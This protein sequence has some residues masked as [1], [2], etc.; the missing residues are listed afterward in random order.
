MIRNSRGRE[1]ILE[2][3]VSLLACPIHGMAESGPQRSLRVDTKVDARYY[4]Y[5]FLLSA[6]VNAKIDISSHSIDCGFVRCLFLKLPDW[7]LQVSSMLSTH[8]VIQTLPLNY[9]QHF[10]SRA[11]GEHTYSI[12]S[13]WP[14]YFYTKAFGRQR[15]S[16][17]LE[18]NCCI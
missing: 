18:E 6:Q 2:E 5:G 7:H 8:V 16:K 10:E 13:S 17:E 14:P 3:A 12:T 1:Q 9:R 4:D 15:S 11:E